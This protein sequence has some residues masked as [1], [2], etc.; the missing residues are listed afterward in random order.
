M[1]FL[2]FRS[3]GATAT[4]PSGTST[5]HGRGLSGEVAAL[6]M[7]MR[8][9]DRLVAEEF[10]RRFGQAPRPVAGALGGYT[11][12]ETC[13]DN[14]EAVAAMN[15]GNPGDTVFRFSSA[16]GFEAF[17][18]VLP[19]LAFRAFEPQE[20]GRD[21]LELLEQALDSS[22]FPRLGVEQRAALK[23]LLEYCRAS[24]SDLSD[25]GQHLRFSGAIR[26][27]EELE[28][29][30]RY[31]RPEPRTSRFSCPES[32]PGSAAMFRAR[33]LF[34]SEL[35]R[36]GHAFKHD[37]KSGGYRIDQGDSR[38]RVSL[39]NIARDLEGEDADARMARFVESILGTVAD[40]ESRGG[41][42]RL[43]W[44]LEPGDYASP[45]EIREPMSEQADRVL[46]LYDDA[47]N[48][49][50]WATPAML[51]GLNV[52]AARAG[53][54]ALRNLAAELAATTVVVEDVRGV[55]LAML[56]TTLP[57]KASL[58]M[59]PNLKEVVGGKIGWPLL[60]VAPVRDFLWLWPAEHDHFVAQTGK[61][62]VS[63]FNGSPYPVSTEVFRI[64]DDGIRA[65]GS[66]P[67][68]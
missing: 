21:S 58:L 57:I 3:S 25:D 47:V 50:I 13:R 10:K 7:K 30:G 49:L 16:M 24:K 19:H 28:Q 41:I 52:T 55:P 22:F 9:S 45:P 66:F 46:I 35:R 59:A 20:D 33:Q 60:A 68:Q 67:R 56:G 23:A 32:R 34:E 53:E 54:I 15:P 48:H 40:R 44:S 42:D 17:A 12:C 31:L 63:E 29:H 11:C 61:T 4:F 64:D 51:D 38:M 62:V 27:L 2:L 1:P 65:I 37:R 6:G 18:F 8:E 43:F 26:A 39:D 14:C 5:C 36:R